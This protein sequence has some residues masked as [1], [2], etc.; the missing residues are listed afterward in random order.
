MPE[1]VT[2]DIIL[3]WIE[4]QVQER[5]VIDG[6]MYMEIAFKINALLQGE[7]EKLFILEKEVAEMTKMLLEDPSMPANRAKLTIQA[8]K[9]YLGVRVQQSKI[10]RALEII[11]LCKLNARLSQEVFK[12]QM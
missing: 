5:Q 8:T 12:A 2:L 4:K 10:N 9:E 1:I 7:Q 3:D 6:H 11:R